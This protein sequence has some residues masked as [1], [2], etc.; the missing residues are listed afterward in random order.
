[1]ALMAAKLNYFLV[2]FNVSL[3]S[4]YNEEFRNLRYRQSL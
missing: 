1:M 2:V 4:I 3:L